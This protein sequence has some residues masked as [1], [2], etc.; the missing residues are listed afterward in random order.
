MRDL[1][2][3]I[4][5]CLSGP[6]NLYPAERAAECRVADLNH[7]WRICM[8]DV[9]AHQNDPH[10]PGWHGGRRVSVQFGDGRPLVYYPGDDT[11]TVTT[12]VLPWGQSEW[13]E[14]SRV[15]VTDPTAPR[16]VLRG[17]GLSIRY[18]EQVEE[19]P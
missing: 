4:I 11:V 7:D 14:T 18:H 13:C 15:V 2:I 3:V 9:Q 10:Q 6:A 12:E 17:L 1:L 19:T 5:G 8:L 16:E